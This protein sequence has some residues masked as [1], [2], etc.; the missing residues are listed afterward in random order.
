[1]RKLQDDGG[2]QPQGMVSVS[3]Q[4]PQSGDEGEYLATCR[5]NPMPPSKSSEPYRRRTGDGTGLHHDL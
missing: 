4:S 1:M 5:S 2:I 3:R